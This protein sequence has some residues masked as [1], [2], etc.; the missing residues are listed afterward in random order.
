[1]EG[2]EQAKAYAEADFD[3][4][5]AAFV[6]RFLTAFPERGPREIVDLGCG[7]ADIAIRIVRARPSTSL[8][9]V[10]GSAAMLEQARRAIAAAGVGDQIE[11]LQANIPVGD[12]LD[13]RF[14]VIISN[15]LLHHLHDPD[16]LWR[17]V[18]TLARAGAAVLVV[19]LFRPRSEAAV[20][21]LVEAYMSDVP[22]VLARD[23]ENSLHAAFT[24]AEVQAQ[25]AAYPSLSALKIE[26][27]SDR[28]LAVF[29]HVASAHR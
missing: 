12:T 7:P 8:L 21:K 20:Q 28:H 29:G 1:M 19:D 18:A 3:D 5:N 9:A 24:V 27:I 17:D 23:F 22:T 14:D 6:E 16:G 4:V 10:D 13:R 25:L 11:L 26:E 2:V 15:S